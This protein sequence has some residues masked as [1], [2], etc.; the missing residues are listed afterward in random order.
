MQRTHHS[1]RAASTRSAD[2]WAPSL[3]SLLFAQ[4]RLLAG[5]AFGS[6]LRG[7]LLSFLES[8][9]VA[10]DG[11]NLRAVHESIDERDN[12]GGIGEHLI[13]FAEG[14]VCREHRGSLLIS[15]RNHLK[16]QIGVARVIRQ[17]ADLVDTK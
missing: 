11:K 16:E 5:S 3:L 14:F 2:H 6:A 1:N 10:S 9:A 4:S 17:I 12:A 8:I 15:S 13:P 7:P